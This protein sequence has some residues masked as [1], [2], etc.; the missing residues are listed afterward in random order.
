MKVT[1]YFHGY[2]TFLK[3]HYIYPCPKE[4]IYQ[5]YILKGVCFNLN[6]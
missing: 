6:Q 1:A 3:V 4:F 5:M 2:D